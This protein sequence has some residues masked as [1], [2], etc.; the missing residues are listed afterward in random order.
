MEPACWSL[1][2]PLLGFSL[3]K[4]APPSG[5]IGSCFLFVKSVFVAALFAL[6]LLL[7]IG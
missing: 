2:L 3:K 1:A 6:V 5:R 4:L 7:F